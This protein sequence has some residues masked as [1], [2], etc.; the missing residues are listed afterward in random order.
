M[1]K[2]ISRWTTQPAERRWSIHRLYHFSNFFKGSNVF[3][4]ETITFATIAQNSTD[5]HTSFFPLIIGMKLTIILT[6]T[7]FLVH[8]RLHISV[9]AC[10]QASSP[11]RVNCKLQHEK[12]ISMHVTQK[13]N[14]LRGEAISTNQPPFFSWARFN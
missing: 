14:Y 12:Y 9:E 7:S 4:G 2:P 11:P 10:P 3:C 8:V 13:K 6:Y 5:I 1:K